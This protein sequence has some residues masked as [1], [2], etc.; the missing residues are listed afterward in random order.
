MWV[1]SI[2]FDILKALCYNIATLQRGE[3]VMNNEL[4]KEM[5]K[6]LTD[7]YYRIADLDDEL[8]KP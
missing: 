7:E 8:R 1:K 4:L 6:R 3:L 2:K 5:H